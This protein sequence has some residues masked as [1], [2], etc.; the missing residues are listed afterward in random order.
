MEK[1]VWRGF[2]TTGDD[3]RHDLFGKSQTRSF[4]SL[5]HI[6]SYIYLK[7]FQQENGN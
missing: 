6:D 7:A 3:N 5:I 1:F 4:Q 2:A